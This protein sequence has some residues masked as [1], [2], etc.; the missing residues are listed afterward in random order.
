M[1]RILEIIHNSIQIYR[2][3]IFKAIEFG[4]E[5]Y[6]CAG[7]IFLNN[8]GCRLNQIQSTLNDRIHK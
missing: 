1:T 5:S 3:E 4:L 2:Q 8:S 6:Y 7:S